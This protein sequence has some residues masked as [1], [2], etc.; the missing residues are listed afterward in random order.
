MRLRYQKN[1]DR[2][3]SPHERPYTCDETPVNGVKESVSLALGSLQ[4][5]LLT[6]VRHNVNL[7]IMIGN[8]SGANQNCRKLGYFRRLEGKGANAYPAVNAVHLL[9]E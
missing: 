5:S 4:L 6:A 9:H 3:Y 1:K 2:Q 7:F 8:K